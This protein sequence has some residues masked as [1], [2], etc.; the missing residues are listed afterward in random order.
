MHERVYIHNGQVKKCG[1]FVTD[2]RVGNKKTIAIL[3][4]YADAMG[5]K[6]V[7]LSSALLLMHETCSDKVA[8]DVSEVS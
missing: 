6:T 4:A 5:A 1:P 8:Q 2:I 7:S 3:I